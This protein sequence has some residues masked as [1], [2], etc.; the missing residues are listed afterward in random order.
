MAD[1]HT[2]V[3]YAAAMRQNG[4]SDEPIVVLA[5]AHPS[6]F[7]ETVEEAIGGDVP[8]APGLHAALEGD[9]RMVAIPA[10]VTALTDVLEGH[11][12]ELTP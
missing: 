12:S 10:D 5:T 9:E 11:M 1:P 2:A 4:D 3:A 8:L 7:P 6:K